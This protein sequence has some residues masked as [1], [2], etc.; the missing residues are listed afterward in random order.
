MRSLRVFGTDF[1][2]YDLVHWE[3]LLEHSEQ[4][5]LLPN[6]HLISLDMQDRFKSEE[7]TRLPWLLMFISPSLTSFETPPMWSF[8]RKLMAQNVAVCVQTVLSQ[9]CPDL[10]TL[11]L[12][13]VNDD[14]MSPQ[15]QAIFDRLVDPSIS[16][17]IGVLFAES[18]CSLTHLKSSM[19]AIDFIGLKLFG[20]LPATQYLELCF[21]GVE[22]G[23]VKAVDLQPDAFPSLTALHLGKLDCL[24]D[25][26]TLWSIAPLTRKLTSASVQIRNL[27]WERGEHLAPIY[28]VARLLCEYAPL[29]NDLSLRLPGPGDTIDAVKSGLQSLS[30]LPLEHLL[31]LTPAIPYGFH[32]ALNPGLFPSLESL[33]TSE[34]ISSPDLIY[35]AKAMPALRN[36]FAQIIFVVPEDSK[37]EI[38]GRTGAMRV[39][40][41]GSSYRARDVSPSGDAII[42]RFVLLFLIFPH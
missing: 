34:S 5:P 15:D 32:H 6:I 38:L 20:S 21:E 10:Q 7:K 29:V 36:I 19:S 2:R 33:I 23:T 27:N 8:E 28:E 22:P 39:E 42:A 30:K 12:F 13:A 26:A 40:C 3:W 9:R 14:L 37:E 18:F 16:A 25:F 24:E 4:Y 11:E 31:L 1:T 41:H 17:D 35:Y